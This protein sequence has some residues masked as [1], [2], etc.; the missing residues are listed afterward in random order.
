MQVYQSKQPLKHAYQR[1][2]WIVGTIS[3]IL[4]LFLG[5]CGSS[6]EHS[7]AG[8][9]FQANELKSNNTPEGVAG[10]K[11]VGGMTQNASS[12]LVGPEDVLTVQ[13]FQV[14]ELDREVVVSQ[15]GKISLPLVGSV[16]AEGLATRD[17]ERS[18]AVKLREYVQVPQV[19]VG[20][21]EYKSQKF[22][23]EGSVKRPGVYPIQGR[24][25]LLQSIATAHGP[26]NLADLRRVLVFRNFK[27]KKYAATF[28]LEMIRQGKF[29]DPVIVKKDIIV[30]GESGSKRFLENAKV[31]LVPGATL[32]RLGAGL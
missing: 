2:S 31:F 27:E 10:F 19:T 21:K 20:V 14:K 18:I 26:N 6:P 28:D 8:S 4:V 23:V 25:T 9:A 16:K 7:L 29:P 1:P 32:L 24:I 5:A 3:Y 13:V 12:Y 15:Q 30:V 11:P 22:T 17:I